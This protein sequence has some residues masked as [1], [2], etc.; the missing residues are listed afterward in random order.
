MFHEGL[1]NLGGLRVAGAIRSTLGIAFRTHIV[2]MRL[3]SEDREVASWIKAHAEFDTLSSTEREVESATAEMYRLGVKHHVELEIVL[4]R[5]ESKGNIG[6]V[7]SR[8]RDVRYTTERIDDV[9]S[10]EASCTNRMISI[11]LSGLD[12]TEVTIFQF[13][14]KVFKI[15]SAGA[16]TASIKENRTNIGIR[17]VEHGAEC[18]DPVH[19]NVLISGEELVFNVLVREIRAVILEKQTERDLGFDIT[20]IERLIL[21]STHITE[22]FAVVVE[23]AE[24]LG[25]TENC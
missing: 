22:T 3:T 24:C 16:R 18:G 5:N 10:H 11:F 7:V 23:L 17:I 25:T 6:C 9:E 13:A 8:D 20:I 4:G 2:D 15:G 12:A 1:R 19:V 21:G 14:N